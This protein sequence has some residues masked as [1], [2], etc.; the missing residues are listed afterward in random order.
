M[1]LSRKGTASPRL[2]SKVMLCKLSCVALAVAGVSQAMAA[3]DVV[4]N[5]QGYG[6]DEKRQLVQFQLWCLMMLPAKCSPVVTLI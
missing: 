4:T 5:A 3:P 1:S 2:F 6:F